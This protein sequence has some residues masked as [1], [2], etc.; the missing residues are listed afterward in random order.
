LFNVIIHANEVFVGEHIERYNAPST[1]EVEVVILLNSNLTKEILCSHDDNLQKIQSC[2]D[3]TT[4]YNI[5]LH[6]KIT[7]AGSASII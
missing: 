5:I 4:A 7:F 3:L 2:I 6:G 1:S